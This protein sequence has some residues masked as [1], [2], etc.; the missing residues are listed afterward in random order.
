MGVVIYHVKSRVPAL[1]LIYFLPSAHCVL[2]S[3]V[4]IC[5]SGPAIGCPAGRPGHTIVSV[6][7]ISF[8]NDVWI[9][10]LNHLLEVMM[11]FVIFS[12]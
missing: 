9:F 5:C 11:D 7:V 10:L 2:N 12:H 1:C 6:D 8:W 4:L 3:A